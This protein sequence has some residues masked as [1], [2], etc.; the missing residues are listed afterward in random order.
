MDH[1]LLLDALNMR[2]SGLSP[3]PTSDFQSPM[4]PPSTLSLSER[5]V[6]DAERH[7]ASQSPI[8]PTPA[9]PLIPTFDHRDQHLMYDLPPLEEDS[10]EMH[11]L[12]SLANEEIELEAQNLV[13]AATFD[14]D[15]YVEQTTADE[16]YIIDQTTGQA[17]P[18]DRQLAVEA[19]LQSGGF[20]AAVLNLV[21]L[22]GNAFNLPDDDVQE[23]I[24]P[25]SNTLRHAMDSIDP[26]FFK[27]VDRRLTKEEFKTLITRRVMGK[28]LRK[29]LGTQETC[30]VICQ[31]DVRSKQHCSILGCKHFFHIKCARQWFS[32]MCT[33][34]TCPCCRK[35]A[36]EMKTFESLLDTGSGE[37]DPRVTDG[38]EEQLA[39][40]TQSHLLLDDYIDRVD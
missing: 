16:D 28:K 31:E 34:P 10:A 5:A 8:T 2:L 30:C 27:P 36:R 17:F 32:E 24:E 13:E 22:V 14:N 29:E 19:F 11:F 7:R 25:I 20:D 35:D 21:E 3:P 4:T 9:A 18:I 12:Q 26:E 40:T 23:L 33:K 1:N 37:I 39:S 15:Q 6:L 38:N